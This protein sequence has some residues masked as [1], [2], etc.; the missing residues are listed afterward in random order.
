MTTI[1]NL[2]QYNMSIEALNYVL[3]RFEKEKLI[4]KQILGEEIEKS[5]KGVEHALQE[6]G[7]RS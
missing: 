6:R 5:I 2:L 7:G 3:S 1:K 4:G